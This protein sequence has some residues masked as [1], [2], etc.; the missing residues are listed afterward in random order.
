MFL[1]RSIGKAG[2]PQTTER[3]VNPKMVAEREPALILTFS[4]KEKEIVVPVL[5]KSGCPEFALVQ[6]F[7][8]RFL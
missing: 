3:P 1:P 5:G 8:A 7:N 4:P 6:G 2:V